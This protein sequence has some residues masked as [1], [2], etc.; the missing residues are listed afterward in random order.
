[1]IAILRWMERSIPRQAHEKYCR[2]CGK[3]ILER[4]E[5]CPGCGCRQPAP[6]S[7]SDSSWHEPQPRP[8]LVA[9]DPVAGRMGL[10]LA[11]NF[12]W[13]GL[14]NIAVGDSRGW[15][16]GF[17]NWIFFVIG[18]FT[19]FIPTIL[20]YAYCGY[21]GYEYLRFL[22]GAAQGQSASSPA[23][24]ATT[25]SAVDEVRPSLPVVVPEQSFCGG[26]GSK[27]QQLANFC[28]LCGATQR[29]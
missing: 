2:D 6:P 9:R 22:N 7:P 29:Y 17:F 13:N 4:A 20:F 8:L 15:G 25:T 12:L 21:Q 28:S 26:C 23:S 18:Y 14:G 1:M 3:L 16:Y 24:N 10:L 11:L 27:L 5:I 19:L